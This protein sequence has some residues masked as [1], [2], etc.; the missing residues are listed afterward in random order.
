MAK[1]PQIQRK[2]REEVKRVAAQFGQKIT[3]EALAN[4]KYLGQI[5]DGNIAEP[6]F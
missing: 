6:G 3:Y 4:M 5:V 2:A 1:N